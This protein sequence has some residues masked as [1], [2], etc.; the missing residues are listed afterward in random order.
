MAEI[1]TSNSSNKKG[2]VKKLV[3]KSTR[4]D[5]TPMVDLG[6]LLVTF[7][8]FTTTMAEPKAMKINMPYDKADDGG[9]KI[10]ET[11]ALTILL[12]KN[13]G[14][15][16]YEGMP[17]N[18]VYKQTTYSADGLRKLIT[19]KKRSVEATGKE[20]QLI[21]KSS[22]SSSLKNLVNVIDESNIAV[23]KRFFMVEPTEKDKAA[24]E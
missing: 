5:L 9:S 7:F 6:F 11:C 3:K 19:D 12:A 2:I 4:V 13:N 8:V 24:I 1:S 16:Y 22:D 15:Y 23:V 10:C 18:A 17:E 21:I 14:L 20:L